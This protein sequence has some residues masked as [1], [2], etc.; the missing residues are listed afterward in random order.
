VHPAAPPLFGTW[1]ERGKVHAW[2]R[3]SARHTLEIRFWLKSEPTGINHRREGT[4]LGDVALDGVIEITSRH[5]DPILGSF[6]LCLQIAKIVIRLQLRIV[7]TDRE[8]P[9]ERSC[10][11][12]L[13]LFKLAKLLWVGR[14]LGGIDGHFCSV[15]PSVH[16]ICE[17]RFLEVRGPFDRSHQVRYEV[18]PTLILRLD[19]RPGGVDRCRSLNEAIVSAC[20]RSPEDKEK[21]NDYTQ[22]SQAQNEGLVHDVI[23]VLNRILEKQNWLKMSQVFS[24]SALLIR[25]FAVQGF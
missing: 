16:D 23:D 8:Q 18:G 15:R 17:C 7:L 14:S 4:D 19:L 11:R 25:C 6:N 12:V 20:Y 24:A 13:S 9:A 2:R 1:A 10:Q 3:F 21:Q 5:G 22:A